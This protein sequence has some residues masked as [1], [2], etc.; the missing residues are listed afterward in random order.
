[1]LWRSARGVS[2][3][4]ST[5]SLPRPTSLRRYL[6]VAPWLPLACAFTY[7]A[8]LVASFPRINDAI[9]LNP[10]AA[11]A[12]I[13]ALDLESGTKGGLIYVGEATHL[14]TI[15]LLVATRWM[16]FRRQL[17]D[18][19][20][21][22]AFL[23]TSGVIAWACSKAAGRW[24]ALLSMSIGVAA[25]PPVLMTVLPKGI[26]GLTFLADAVMVAFLAFYATKWKAVTPRWRITACG[27]VVI[28]AGTTIASDP[29]FL[30]TGLIPFWVATTA[31]YVI[32]RNQK[33]KKLALLAT[34][35][36]MV[37]LAVAAAV[38]L[39]MHLVGFRK[40]YATDGYAL[41]SASQVLRNV[42]SFWNHLLILGN[43]FFLGSP[44]TLGSI[45]ILVMAIFLGG[46]ILAVLVK[47]VQAMLLTRKTGSDQPVT[48]YLLFWVSSGLAVFCAYSLSTFAAGPSDTSRYVVPMF[49]VL[50]A[51]VP[52]LGRRPGWAR[53]G[54]LAGATLFCALSLEGRVGV[55]AYEGLQ[56]FRSV[57]R[58]G[59]EV[60]SFLDSQGLTRGY[61]GYFNAHPLTYLSDMRIHVYPVIPCQQPVRNVLC[62]FSVNTRTAWY[63]PHSGVRS[64]IVFDAAGPPSLSAA[65]A[66]DYG[67]PAVTRHFGNISVFVYD[68][69]VAAMFAPDCP[70]GSA[71]FFCPPK[72]P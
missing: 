28:I 26:H 18:L 12:P 8:W 59:P 3:D 25:T 31:L 50:A 72:P 38:A 30:V 70:I 45:F 47:T 57:Q 27:V 42:R 34:S 56:V 40:T 48:L 1:M 62:P 63:R 10:D 21:F 15:L 67:P 65:P 49:Y 32:N 29:L 68:Y 22:L 52:I 37:A 5:Q 44:L 4:I 66:P 13:L 51:T 9:H 11:W 17:W 14:S 36:S 55:L 60:I 71:G 69:D 35:V 46:S 61:A 53:R 2:S 24:A 41:A 54:A 39:W 33:N 7:A 43:A 19:F 16:P 20:P 23:A 6:S 58:E 64:F